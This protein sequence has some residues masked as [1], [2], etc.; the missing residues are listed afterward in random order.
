M[1]GRYTVTKTDQLADRF[2]LHQTV[3]WAPRY[4]VAPTQ[5][6]P[7]IL[8]DGT[9]HAEL[10]RWGLV[11]YGSKDLK[12]GAR[13]INVRA[14]GITDRAPFRNA[15]EKRRCLVPADGFYEWKKVGGKRQ[16]FYFALNS[17]DL[18]AFA[19]LWTAWKS[20]GGDWVRTFTIVTTAPNGLM[21]PV[22]D[23]MPVMLT[24]EA[25]D[26]WMDSGAPSA[27]LRELL[28]PYAAG[29]MTAFEVSPLVNSW[30]NEDPACIVPAEESLSPREPPL[31][32][33]G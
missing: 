20:S 15:F 6:V 12:V 31:F 5:D 32:P 11:P 18:F 33:A 4:N 28:V 30:Q 23:R 8:D 29:E 27:D 13:M 1:C 19:G 7:V 21:E 10:V 24:R 22:H 16:P 26:V 25:E 17:R 9:R 3:D 2:S 14:E